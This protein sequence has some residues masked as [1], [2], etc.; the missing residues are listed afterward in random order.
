[1]KIGSTLAACLDDLEA[2]IDGNVEAEL[3]EQWQDFAF[4]RWQGN[5]FHPVRRNGPRAPRIDWPEVRVNDALQ[6]HELMLLQQYRTCSDVLSCGDGQL[7]C[8]RAN[9]GTALVPLLFGA[10]LFLM[11]P[12]TNTLPTSRPVPGR[13]QG[14]QRLIERGI[15]DVN[16]S[17]CARAFET[18]EWF[19]AVAVQYPKIGRFVHIFHPDTQGPMDIAELLWGSDIFYGAMDHPGLLHELLQ[20]I[21]ETYIAVMRRW[22]AVVPPSDGGY[23]AH[24][25]ILHRG[26][27]MLR[28]DSAMNFSPDMYEE[29]IRPYDQRLLAEFGGGAI[30]FCGKCDHYIGMLAQLKD[31]YAVNMSQP[32]LNDIETMLQHTVDKGICLLDVQADAAEALLASGRPLR[33]KLH[34]FGSA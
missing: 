20:L 17:F 32:H 28:D 15:P 29:F 25:G 33:G 2:R 26:R 19:K 16:A 7:M 27:I 22:E 3:F 11:D 5:A 31:L 10:E 9:Y 8:V 30:H 13:A 4:G 14:M 6:K 1:M 12:A 18:A 34:Y 24:W 21:T 23:A